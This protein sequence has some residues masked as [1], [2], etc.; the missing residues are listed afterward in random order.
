[1]QLPTE[2]KLKKAPS[3]LPEIYRNQYE[4]QHSSINRNLTNT[5]YL[6]VNSSDS[7][8]QDNTETVHKNRESWFY[9]EV[10]RMCHVCTC[11]IDNFMTLISLNL[12]KV[13]KLLILLEIQ[14]DDDLI[15]MIYYIQIK[16]FDQ[17]KF[18]LGQE[19]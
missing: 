3:I 2:S 19:K 4:K 17:L 1:M 11:S 18:W 12:Q 15:K 16:K 10:E 5:E 14:I 13:Q 6:E 9:T 7:E 8:Q